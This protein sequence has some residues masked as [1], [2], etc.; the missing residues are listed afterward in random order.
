MQSIDALA[1]RRAMLRPFVLLF[2]VLMSWFVAPHARAETDCPSL[3]IAV[4]A[5]LSTAAYI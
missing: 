5:C 3:Y 1:A 2:F 4:G